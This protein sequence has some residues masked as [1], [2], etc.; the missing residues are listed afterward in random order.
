MR[1]QVLSY[2]SKFI[3]TTRRWVVFEL[4]A[5]FRCIIERINGNGIG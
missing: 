1:Q 4:H 3:M 2:C 5:P